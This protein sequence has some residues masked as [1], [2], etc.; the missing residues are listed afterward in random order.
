METICL[1]QFHLFR[2]SHYHEPV[3]PNQGATN[4]LCC[5]FSK[6][7][8]CAKYLDMTIVDV[9]ENVCSFETRPSQSRTSQIYRVGDQSKDSG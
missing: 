6:L 2:S 3:L 9:T 5:T 4:L 8:P 1:I 7:S